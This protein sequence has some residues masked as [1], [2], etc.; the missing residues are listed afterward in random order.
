[1]PFPVV[2]V[3][4]V[5]VEPVVVVLEVSVVSVSP[6]VVDVDGVVVVDVEVVPITVSGEGVASSSPPHPA[7][8]MPI[9]ARRVARARAVRRIAPILYTR[10]APPRRHPL[11]QT[12][13][14]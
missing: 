6:V 1:L 12:D 11:P 9:T 4:V 8:A 13:A 10:L 5:V 7:A 3:V 14:G 2:P